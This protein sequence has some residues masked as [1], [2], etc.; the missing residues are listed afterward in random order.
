MATTIVRPSSTTDDGG[1][2]SIRDT[3][4]AW[5]NNTSTYDRLLIEV[6]TTATVRYHTFAALGSSGYSSVDLKLSL[7]CNVVDG[8][9]SG[10]V[11]YSTDGGSGWTSI[12][13]YTSVTAQEELT[14]SLPT[15]QD[16]TTVQVKFILT[17]SSANTSG[18]RVHELW[19]EAVKPENAFFLLF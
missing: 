17:N 9:L 19:I 16:T 12:K 2:W 6:V 1:T 13:T 7:A 10:E 3:G 18:L 11:L 15:S 14:V 8:G 4:S 5:D